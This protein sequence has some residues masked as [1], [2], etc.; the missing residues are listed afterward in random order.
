MSSPPEWFD[1]VRRYRIAA[2]FLYIPFIASLVTWTYGHELRDVL[3]LVAIR[4][5]YWV[6]LLLL[7][8]ALAMD[9][10]EVYAGKRRV[11]QMI[12]GKQATARRRKRNRDLQD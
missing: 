9:A 7:T 2:V 5:I 3:P 4:S 1:R 12:E 11:K 6:G 10:Y 8:V